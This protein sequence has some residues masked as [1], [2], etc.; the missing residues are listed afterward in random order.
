LKITPL[1]IQ[2]K[3]FRTVWRGLDEAEVDAFLDLVAGELEEAVKEA[4]NLKEELRRKTARLEE[5][6]EREKVLQ[7]TLLTAQKITSDIKAQARRESELMLAE[8]EKQ[9]E[10]VVQDA[11]RRLVELIQDINAM[12]GQRARF[13]AE[14]RQMV[15]GHVALLDTFKGQPQAPEISERIEDNVAFL[16][17]RRAAEGDGGGDD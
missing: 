5:Y 8:A 7:E 3:T 6:K 11:Q 13:E 17:P 16:A 10:K 12:K 14:L 4:I 1:D 2:K 15:E 9:A